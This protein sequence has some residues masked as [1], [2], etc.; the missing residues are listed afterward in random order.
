[1]NYTLGEVTKLLEVSKS[2]IR[3]YERQGLLEISR[4]RQ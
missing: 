3:N 1:M 4:K 2:T